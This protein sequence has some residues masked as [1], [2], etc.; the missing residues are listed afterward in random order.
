MVCEN[1]G[2]AI[3]FVSNECG[4]L[5][6]SLKRIVRIWENLEQ[7]IYSLKENLLNCWCMFMMVD[8]CNIL[9]GFG[10]YPILRNRLADFRTSY[11]PPSQF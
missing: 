3:S 4:S 8:I 2:W 9:L 1:Q 7:L 5:L 11:H 6:S 10:G